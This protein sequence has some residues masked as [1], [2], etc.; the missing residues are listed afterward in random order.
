VRVVPPDAAAELIAAALFPDELEPAVAPGASLI[1]LEPF[2]YRAAL[3]ATQIMARRRGCLICDSVGLGKSYVALELARRAHNAGQA[4]LLICPAALRPQWTRLLRK[5]LP[6][7]GAVILTHTQ[8]SRGRFADSL[9][10]SAGLLIV[11]EAHAFRSSN[12][13]RHVA[14]R[15]LA[16][17]RNVC[18]ITATPVNNSL[19]DLYNLVRIFADDF[20]FRDIGIAHLRSFFDDL[21]REPAAT[22]SFRRLIRDVVIRRSRD[23]VRAELAAGRSRLRFPILAPPIPIVYDADHGDADAHNAVLRAISELSLAAMGPNARELLTCILLKRL[24]SSPAALRATVRR[25]LRFHREFVSACGEGLWLAPRD[26]HAF[27]GDRGGTQLLIRRMA[28][29]PLKPSDDV[30]LLRQSALRDI[31]RLETIMAGIPSTPLA[32]SKL[33]TLKHYL[34]NTFHDRQILIFSEFRETAE[35]IWRDLVGLG[36]VGMVHGGGA[37]LGR[38]IASR[39]TVVHRFDRSGEHSSRARPHARELV[40]I[41]IATDVLAEGLNLQSCADVLS[42]DL[43]WNPVRLMQRVGRIDRMGSPHAVV[44]MYNFLPDEKL[45]ERLQLVSRLRLKLHAIGLSLGVERPVLAESIEPAPLIPNSSAPGSEVV[46]IADPTT[47][48]SDDDPHATAVRAWL[49]RRPI[50]RSAACFAAC[51]DDVASL[52][53]LHDVSGTTLCEDLGVD[54]VAARGLAPSAFIAGVFRHDTFISCSVLFPGSGILCEADPCRVAALCV[55]AASRMRF[56]PRA[57]QV[58]AVL[59]WLP[60]LRPVLTPPS[61][62][63]RSRMNRPLEHATARTTAHRILAELATELPFGLV[64]HGAGPDAVAGA[65]AAI[66][67]LTGPACD[68]KTTLLAVV[69]AGFPTSF[70]VDHPLVCR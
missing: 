54:S 41:L 47:S 26:L 57:D 55:G 60:R 10:D 58:Q 59:A 70:P 48:H 4:T 45:E 66:R 53:V 52:T 51:V 61:R 12:A 29:R 21:M 30:G 35:Y 20:A 16:A 27:G 11:D 36:R 67:R 65:E 63:S 17:S 40:H 14:V 62:G 68:A 32:D 23:D 50:E 38:G 2:Q 5:H 22:L 6:A 42:Y 69:A 7:A 28:L 15:R 34:L 33:S 1:G 46:S 8:L 44:R 31:E 19:L 64:S 24:E 18:L 25:L 9:A 43:P 3:R 49:R 39:S 13:R 37:R 56:H